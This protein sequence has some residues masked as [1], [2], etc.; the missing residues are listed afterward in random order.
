MGTKP[1]EQPQTLKLDVPQIGGD[2]HT[3]ERREEG[4]TAPCA[5]GGSRYR[6]EITPKIDPK[7]EPKPKIDPPKP[8]PK[9]EPK[10]EP[11]PK[12]D[13]PKIDPKVDPK[14]KVDPPKPPSFRPWF[15]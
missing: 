5:Q 4:A 8:D 10:I 9:V 12:V 1:I 13:P 3:G 7:V 2:P 11:K 15:A 6:A 14:P